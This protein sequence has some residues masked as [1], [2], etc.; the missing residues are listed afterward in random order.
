MNTKLIYGGLACFMLASCSQETFETPV[1]EQYAQEFT[2]IFGE[3]DPNQNWSMATRSSVTVSAEPG[4]TVSVYAYNGSVYKL[5]ARYKDF[6]GNETISFDAIQGYDRI[7]V[8]DGLNSVET[9]DGSSVSLVSTRADDEITYTK[10]DD[11]KEIDVD[12]LRN[13][14]TNLLPESEDNTDNEGLTTDFSALPKPNEQVTVYP[15]YCQHLYS[16]AVGV[17]T[18]DDNGKPVKQEA[19][20]YDGAIGDDLQYKTSTNGSWQNANSERS[21]SGS[22]SCFNSSNASGVTNI[23]AKGYT[24]AIPSNTQYG[25]YIDVYTSTSTSSSSSGNSRPGRNSES[26][27][28]TDDYSK[29]NISATYYS[30]ASLNNGNSYASYV[31]SGDNTFIGFEDQ[32]ASGDLNDIILMLDPVPYIIDHEELEFIIAAEDLGSTDD[33]DFNDVVFKVAH[34]AGETTATITP[35]AA[36]GT[37]PIHLKYDGQEIGGEFHSLFGVAS[38]Q[39]VNTEEITKEADSIEIEVTKDFSLIHYEKYGEIQ[40]GSDFSKFTIDV[41]YGETTLTA[42]QVGQAPQ[43]MC[44]PSTWKWPKERVNILQAYPKFGDWGKNYTNA[45]WVNTVN[46]ENVVK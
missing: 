35:L 23:Q 25:F 26:H 30:Q 20:F 6:S 33:F 5:A 40:E 12:V 41:D 22:Y 17:Y 38:N 11:Y 3:I 21:A 2:K 7:I 34:V 29:G 32:D 24:L 45:T 27:T 36:G 14:L 39:M 42:P 18:L 10:T 37:K 43:I 1:Q 13:I 19:F 46:E 9:S 28:S 8:S 44:L 15:V 4:S 16:V 31:V